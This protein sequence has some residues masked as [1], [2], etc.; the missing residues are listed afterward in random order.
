MDLQCARNLANWLRHSEWYAQSNKVASFFGPPCRY[1]PA[2]NQ[3]H[4]NNYITKTTQ[5]ILH[6]T[7]SPIMSAI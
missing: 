6:L 4:F 3:S 5:L 7:F 1:V 2:V